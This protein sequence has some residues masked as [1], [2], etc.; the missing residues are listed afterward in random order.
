MVSSELSVVSFFGGMGNCELAI[1]NGYGLL[2]SGIS[3]LGK[4][5][6]NS[7]QATL[8]VQAA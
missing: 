8:S 1:D 3:A 6:I 5:Y 7:V 2:Y 4:G